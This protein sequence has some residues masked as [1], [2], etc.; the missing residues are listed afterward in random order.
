MGPNKNGDH[1]RCQ[2]KTPTPFEIERV[3]NGK[4]LVTSTIHLHETKNNG[5]ED[6]I[7]QTYCCLLIVNNPAQQEMQSFVLSSQDPFHLLLFLQLVF[8][9]IDIAT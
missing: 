7:I 9:V 2:I 8:C 5:N 1:K 6:Q 4:S 3:T